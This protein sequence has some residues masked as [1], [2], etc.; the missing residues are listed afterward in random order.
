MRAR[1]R[2]HMAAMQN[3]F[4]HPLRAAGVARPS[5]QDRFHERKFGLPIGT[6]R[7]RHHIAHH[8]HIGFE[9]HLVGPKAFNQVDAQR[10]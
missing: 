7:A 8:E 6:M 10:A 9:S 5:V 4:T 3:V 2:H 1:H